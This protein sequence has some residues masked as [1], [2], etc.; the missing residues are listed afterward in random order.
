MRYRVTT[1]AQ[2]SVQRL[3]WLAAEID[4][5][6]A[7]ASADAQAEWVALQSTWPSDVELRQGWIS[8][9]EEVLDADR[10]RVRRFGEI[11]RRISEQ[12]PGQP[13]L[14]LESPDPNLVASAS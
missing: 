8:I 5:Y 7:L 12:G 10:H 3:R 13:A 6:I 2:E 14:P 4:P 9:S 11:L 1:R